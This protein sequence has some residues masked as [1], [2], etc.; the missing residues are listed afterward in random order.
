[1]SSVLQ[2]PDKANIWR[3]TFNLTFLPHRYRPTAPPGNVTNIQLTD[4]SFNTVLVK[5]DPPKNV[6]GIYYLFIYLFI[7]LTNVYTGY[8]L[9]TKY[10]YYGGPVIVIHLS[11]G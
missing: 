11:T 4:L 5:W 8:P 6:E 10:C 1:M 7:C 2:T 9:S 3:A